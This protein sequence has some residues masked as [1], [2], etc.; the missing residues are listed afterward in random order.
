MDP[1]AIPVAQKP[2]PVTCHLQKPLKEWLE[3]GVKENTIEKVPDGETIAWYS[4][5]VVQLKPKYDDIKTEELDSQMIRA[6]TDMRV[7]N[8][9]MKRSRFVHSPRFKDFIYCLHDCK[10]F[11][12]LDLRQIYHQLTLNHATRQ[13]ATFSAPWRNYRPK[14]LVFR[15][16]SSQDVFNEAMF[17]AFGDIPHRLN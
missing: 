2:H 6:S 3:Q 4:P 10:I 15:A 7:P 13:V 14:T 9:A 16:T 12:K 5:Q 11:R 17:R 8:E 1:K